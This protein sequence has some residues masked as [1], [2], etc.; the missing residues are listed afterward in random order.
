MFHHPAK[1]HVLRSRFGQ[2]VKQIRA[3]LSIVFT[4]VFDLSNSRRSDTSASQVVDAA[5]KNRV[6]AH[7]APFAF[8]VLEIAVSL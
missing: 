2:F 7:F 6:V 1:L 3:S 5:L 4:H 8:I